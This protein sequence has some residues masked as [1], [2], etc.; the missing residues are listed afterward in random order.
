MLPVIMLSFFKDRQE[1]V[2]MNKKISEWEE[3]R[4]AS[5]LVL[6]V[7]LKKKVGAFDKD[8]LRDAI[9]YENMECDAEINFLKTENLMKKVDK[10]K[11]PHSDFE[12]KKLFLE[13]NEHYV[14]GR[15][16]LAKKGLMSS[17]K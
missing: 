7:E 12:G 9:K 8:A 6:D 5:S 2:K 1:W 16:S 17:T 15:K 14:N 11:I 13:H 3:K 4:K 10:Y